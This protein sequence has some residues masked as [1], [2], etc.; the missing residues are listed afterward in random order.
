MSSFIPSI[1]S[2]L[3]TNEE[4]LSDLELS[5]GIISSI[6]LFVCIVFIIWTCYHNDKL[7]KQKILKKQQNQSV[8]IQICYDDLDEESKKRWNKYLELV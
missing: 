5:I 1:S 3:N 4:K 2:T 6:F 8:E 7:Q